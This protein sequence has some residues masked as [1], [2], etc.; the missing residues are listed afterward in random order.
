MTDAQYQ[1]IRKLLRG[2]FK[3]YPTPATHDEYRWIDIDGW[4]YDAKTFD[5]SPRNLMVSIDTLGTACIPL[6]DEDGS[7][8]FITRDQ[9]DQWDAE[10]REELRWADKD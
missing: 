2:D 9:C 10:Q 1:V 7:W 3:K 4:R 6:D 8:T 5:N